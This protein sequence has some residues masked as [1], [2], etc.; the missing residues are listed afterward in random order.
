M[1]ELPHS[2]E[3]FRRDLLAWADR[4]NLREF[5][6]RDLEKSIYEVFIAEFFLTQTP[7]ENVAEVY[8]EF[9]A[10]YPSLAALENTT[11]DELAEVISPLGFQRMRAEAL[12]EIAAQN[13]RLPT[14]RQSLLALPRVGPYIADATLCFGARERRPIVDRNVARIYDRVFGD[15]WPNDDARQRTFAAAMLPDGATA[16]RRYNLALL[17][18]G[19]EICTKRSPSCDSCF[20]SDYCKFYRAE[21]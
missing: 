12:T 7:A 15:D 11:S 21:D 17:D 18:F 19:A 2:S 1:T 9:V 8:P 14:D 16:V 4:G 20:A 6:W 10:K 3:T 13:E 5:P